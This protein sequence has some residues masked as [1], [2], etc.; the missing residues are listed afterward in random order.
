MSEEY[1]R[2]SDRRNQ[3][4]INFRYI[5]GSVLITLIAALMLALAQGYILLQ[6]EDV[7][8]S[9]IQNNISI[10]QKQDAQ[11]LNHLMTKR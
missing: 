2:I 10:M 5:I 7:R 1:R 6:R 4:S 9:D 8:I 11:I 3:N